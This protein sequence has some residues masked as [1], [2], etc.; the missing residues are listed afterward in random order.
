MEVFA[1]PKGG[2]RFPSRGGGEGG[3]KG[4]HLLKG[5]VGKLLPCLDWGG[6]G[7]GVRTQKVLDFPIL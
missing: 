5:C 2:A 7:G 3:G 6:G 1:I 4:F